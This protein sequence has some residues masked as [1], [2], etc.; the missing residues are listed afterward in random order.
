[1]KNSLLLFAAFLAPCFAETL[2]QGER[3]RLMSEMHATRKRFLDSIA[4]L[5]EKQWNFKPDDKT[6]SVAE[7]A[8]HITL[9]E[10]FIFDLV[11]QRLMKTPAA[12]EK[13]DLVKGKDEFMMTA[14]R[15]RSAKF[16]A[17]EPLKP[18]TKQWPTIEGISK[19]FRTRRDAHIAY[20]QTT[21]DDL[22][23]HFLDHP[24]AKT[25]DGYQWLILVSSHSDRHVSQILEVKARP[26]FPK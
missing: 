7:C 8:E 23:S 6:W 18:A 20:V 21:Q 16:Q 25:A 2:T 15:D 3:D 4:G 14:I 11:T 22:R 5:S 12:P 24:V 26:D 1:M 19:E 9:S 10:N 17:P 13:K